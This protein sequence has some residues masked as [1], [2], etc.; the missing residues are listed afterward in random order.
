MNNNMSISIIQIISITLLVFLI[1]VLLRLSK[2]LKYERRIDPFSLDPID[3]DLSFFDKVFILLWRL[4]RFISGVLSKSKLINKSSMKY[5]KYISFE[6]KDIKSGVDYISLKVLLVIGV[7]SLYF[8]SLMFRYSKYNSITLLLASILAFYLPD[9]YLSNNYRRRKKLVEDDLLKAIIIMNNAFKS[10]SNVT[11]AVE[12]VIEEL[13]GPI[14][15]EFKKIYIDINYGL[16]L[17][18][19]F[20]R[21]YDRV[22]LDDAKYLTS[23]LSLIN[24][25]GGNIVKVFSLIE[26]AF[27][28]KK[29]LRNEL[30]SLTAQS[31]FVFRFLLLLPF[32]FVLLILILNPAYFQPLFQYKIGMLVI[33][34]IVLLYMLYVII[35]RK[36]LRVKIWKISK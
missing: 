35:V 31:V 25:T 20:K 16:S 3:Y 18:V 22:K 26:K 23:S 19:V 21:F 17:D 14:K 5:D 9:L 2:A 28:D 8:L 1:V 32:I 15:D 27:F 24:K 34:L 12:I 33:G 7:D 30:K 13:D 6:E 11:Q 29:K 4:I 10:G 36:L